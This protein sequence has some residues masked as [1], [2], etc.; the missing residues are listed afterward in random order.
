MSWIVREIASAGGEVSFADFME[1]ALYHPEH[2]YYSAAAPRYGRRGDYLT[3]PTASPWYARVLGG[4]MA[5]LA[6]AVGPIVFVDVASGDGALAAALLGVGTGSRPAWLRQLVSVE[7]SAAMRALQRDRLAAAG[8]ARVSICRSLAEVVTPDG[9]TVVH[10]CELYDAQPVHR[11]VQR[12]HG[13]QELRVA[14][15]DG[16]CVWREVPA[17]VELAAYFAGHGVELLAGQVAEAALGAVALHRDVLG[18]AGPDG[19]A[20]VV[21]YGY[22]SRRL[23]DPRG[24]AGG[25]LAVYRAHRLSR[26]PLRD[27]G[28]CDLTAHVNWDDLRRA[29]RSAGWSEI[30]LDPLALFLARVGLVGEVERRGLGIEAELD[31]ATLAERQELKRI[32]DPEGMGADL[33]VLVQGVG[34]LADIAAR[35]LQDLR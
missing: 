33:K 12:E 6:D 32:L 4:W 19:L 29:A 9:P 23:Y 10:A 11:V 30:G 20:V 15:E 16:R 14:A 31:A 26:D 13:L 35:L 7:R 5:G 21:D 24:R 25:S 2:G 18:V 1:L 34:P 17:T 22:E 27:P 3:A 28:Q 8:D